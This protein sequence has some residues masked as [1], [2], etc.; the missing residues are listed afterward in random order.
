MQIT[1]HIHALKIPFQLTIRPG[2]SLA[3]F[4]YV[5]LIH[6]KDEV[7][8]IDSGVAG[9]ER[10]IFDYLKATGRRP[11]DISLLVLTHSH[12]DHLGAA[13]AV[14]QATG[15]IVAAHPVE[16]P[17][18]EDVEVQFQQR[19]VPGF[20]TLVGGGVPVDRL[21]QDGELL[22]LDDLTL[23]VLHTPGHSQGSL[24]LWLTPDRA[25]ICGDAVP[26][27][28][29]VPI[30]EDVLQSLRSVR[31][32]REMEDVRVLLSSWD[33]PRPGEQAGPL[34]SQS[35]D[36][37]QRIH[38]SVLHHAAENMNSLE[39]CKRVLAD[40]KLP[41]AAA[42]P[43]VARTFAAHLAVEHIGNIVEAASRV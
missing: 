29:S 27:P 9:S 5:Y 12:P 15:C 10:V 17:W 42:T 11:D 18:I 6:G 7:W 28:D 26:L 31:R 24:S 32:L 35:L 38:R 16:K 33:E 8:L 14:K 39:L 4:V 22:R 25:M 23:Q 13:L 36:Y 34:L 30:Y 2:V 3:R 20:H 41:E 1:E 21:L 40:L 43:L 37:L 19:P